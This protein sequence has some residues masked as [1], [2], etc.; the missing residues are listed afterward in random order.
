MEPTTCLVLI[1]V[2]FTIGLIMG[3]VLVTPR[4]RGPWMY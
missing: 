2:A 3:V 4:S 1:L